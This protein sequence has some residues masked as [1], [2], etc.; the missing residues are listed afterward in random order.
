[1]TL[2]ER[3]GTMLRYHIKEV[4]FFERYDERSGEAYAGD[5]ATYASVTMALTKEKA[6]H[7]PSWAHY[8]R[9]DFDAVVDNY[10]SKEILERIYEDQMIAFGPCPRCGKNKAGRAT[11]RSRRAKVMICNKCGTEEAMMDAI[12]ES[13]LLFSKWAYIQVLKGE[14]E[15]V[16]V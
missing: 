6:F 12:K 4:F 3:Y 2:I 10:K 13:P 14:G 11:A 7:S 8:E 1:M 15:N 9:Q 5:D 16:N